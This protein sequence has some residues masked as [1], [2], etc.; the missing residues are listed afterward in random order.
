MTLSMAAFSFSFERMVFFS[1]LLL[2]YCY[3]YYYEM[4]CQSD[5]FYYYKDD[6]VDLCWCRTLLMT[7]T[8]NSLVNSFV[9]FDVVVVVVVEVEQSLIIIKL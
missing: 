9:L 4:K 8:F 1:T 3:Y 5:I 7:Y 6:D 2:S